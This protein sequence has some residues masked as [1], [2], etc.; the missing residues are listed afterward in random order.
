MYPSGK[1]TPLCLRYDSR[2]ETCFLASSTCIKVEKTTNSENYLF[3]CSSTFNASPITK[4]EQKEN[5]NLCPYI[6]HDKNSKL[7]SKF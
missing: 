2:I 1:S 4:H 3:P 7:V 5:P 6:L